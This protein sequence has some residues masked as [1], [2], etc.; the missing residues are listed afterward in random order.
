MKV[1]FNQ[2]NKFGKIYTLNICTHQEKVFKIYKIMFK[3]LIL[4]I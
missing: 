1:N 4:N 2:F 3:L